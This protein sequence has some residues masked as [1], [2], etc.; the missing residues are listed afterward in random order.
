MFLDDSR[1]VAGREADKQRRA[2]RRLR[3]LLAG[4]AVLL[5][6]ALVAGG[7][8]LVARGRANRAATAAVAQ[9]LGA[10]ALLAKD[11]D[12]AL[13]LTRQGVAL[14]DSRATEGNLQVALMRSPGLIRTSRPLPGS[15]LRSVDV[16]PDGSRVVAVTDGRVAVLDPTTLRTTRVFDLPSWIG[17]FLDD[18]R[19][20]VAGP[21]GRQ[22]R[23]LD[24]KTGAQSPI[25]QPTFKATWYDVAADL[26]F[27]GE[28]SPRKAGPGREIRVLALP[29]RRLLHRLVVPVEAGVNLG[30]G[31]ALIWQAPAGHTFDSGPPEK[32]EVWSLEPWRRQAVIAVDDWPG[33]L[34]RSGRLLATARNGRVVVTD[35]RTGTSRVLGGRNVNG[36]NFSR[37]GR[38]LVSVGDEAI[39][40]DV[41]RGVRRETLRGES[42][43]FSSDGETVYTSSSDG[44]VA[45]FDVGGSRRIGRSFR[46]GSGNAIDDPDQVPLGA[47]V[48]PDGRLLAATEHDGR[49]SIVALASGRRVAHTAP[50]AGG[51]VSGVAWAP[52]GKSFATADSRRHVET[53]ERSGSLLRSY[54]SSIPQQTVGAAVAFSPDGKL[55]AASGS[56]YQI[57]VWSVRT[58]KEVTTASTTTT[59][60][61]LA[62]SPDGKTLVASSTD[63]GGS[64]VYGW[65]L[66]DGQPIYVVNV[67]SVADAPQV[68]AFTPDGK[69]IATGGPPGIVKFLDPRTGKPAG[70]PIRT[71][72]LISIDFD[73]TGR[74]MV[75]GGIDGTTRLFDVQTRT[76]YGGPFPAVSNRSAVAAFTPDGSSVVTVNDRG[77]AVL[78]DIRPSS[79]ARHACDVAGRTL[80]R[81]EW[82]QYL[83][84]RSYHPACK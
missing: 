28:A 14:S 60:L 34:D 10:Q 54:A 55:L 4:A 58:G 51:R 8:A 36:L 32:L 66:P 59:A 25:F 13:L 69:L 63:D 39:V 65:G 72:G 27:A 30:A 26:R 52:D 57:H 15:A 5:I 70:R 42:A 40:W 19:L 9:R 61:G 16:S 83:P 21:T 71:G 47:A 33:A 81:A 24:L 46:A 80:T 79:W 29:G 22:M 77:R 64:Y 53:W 35:L 73:R 6:L 41:A 76:A 48:S 31:H 50:A 74:L 45:A 23:A 1:S 11:P 56:D 62:F 44:T 2:N 17:G 75:T 38:S 78:W 67:G 3:G 43:V 84:G 7:F 12:L 18:G 20:V 37:D 82:A 68:V 49:T